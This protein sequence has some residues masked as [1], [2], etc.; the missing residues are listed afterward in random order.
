MNKP[1]SNTIGVGIALLSA[2]LLC[3]SCHVP[4]DSSRGQPYIPYVTDQVVSDISK[5]LD[6]GAGITLKLDPGN[7]KLEMTANNDGATTEWIGGD[8]AKTQPMRQL[9]VTCNMPS[10][11]QLVVTNPTTFGLG[12]QV[13]VTVK[14]T[15]LAQ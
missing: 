4:T 6:D 5:V 15:K 11:G 13:S 12:K 10:T 2:I 14:V 7:Y 8:C 3:S 1:R 9:N